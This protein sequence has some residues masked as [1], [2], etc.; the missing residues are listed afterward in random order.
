MLVWL[1]GTIG[2]NLKSHIRNLPYD[3]SLTLHFISRWLCH[4]LYQER[5]NIWKHF[6]TALFCNRAH[7]TVTLSMFLLSL[8]VQSQTG[9]LC[10]CSLSLLAKCD[11]HNSAILWFRELSLNLSVISLYT[12]VTWSGVTH[13]RR[14]SES[15]KKWPTM[16]IGHKSR[17]IFQYLLIC[18]LCT[19]EMTGREGQEEQWVS[20]SN[21]GG[22]LKSAPSHS[23]QQSTADMYVLAFFITYKYQNILQKLHVWIGGKL[24]GFKL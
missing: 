16:P 22:L 4:G 5:V 1:P 10:F 11:A 24:K 13:Q 7:S 8:H 9:L 6:D 19:Q 3:S 21:R 14:K 20:Y 23:A 15:D 17:G 2:H 18:I 12:A